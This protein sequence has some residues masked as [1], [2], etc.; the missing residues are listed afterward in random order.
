[1]GRVFVKSGISPITTYLPACVHPKFVPFPRTSL[2][3]ARE[4]AEMVMCGAINE[5]LER[6]GFEPR[7]IDILVCARVCGVMVS[8]CIK[9]LV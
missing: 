5:L 2:D 1:M 9:I 3:L 7:Q 8:A 4:E 6:T